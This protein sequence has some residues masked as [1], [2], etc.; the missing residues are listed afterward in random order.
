MTDFQRVIITQDMYDSFY[1]LMESYEGK[2]END[3]QRKF[4]L[5]M[6]YAKENDKYLKYYY[7]DA[8]SNKDNKTKLI[9][10][11][12]FVGEPDKAD[13]IYSCEWEE[14]LKVLSECELISEEVCNDLSVKID[15]IICNRK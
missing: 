3:I 5:F 11:L 1:D 12:K 2:N 13:F 10:C 9:N 8:R 15:K 14:L 7:E 6:L 4:A